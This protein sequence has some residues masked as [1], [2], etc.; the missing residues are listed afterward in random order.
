MSQRGPKTYAIVGPKYQSIANF[1]EPRKQEP[2]SAESFVLS[3]KNYFQVYIMESFKV[4][5]YYEPSVY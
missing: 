3:K 4:K 2:I 5:R 1:F